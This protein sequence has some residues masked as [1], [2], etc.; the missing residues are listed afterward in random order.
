MSVKLAIAAVA[1]GLLTLGAA[2]ADPIWGLEA[3]GDV[4]PVTFERQQLP[5]GGMQRIRH[6]SRSCRGGLGN[7]IGWTAEGDG[8][9]YLFYDRA[10]QILGRVDA[11]GG[12]AYAGVF[13]DGDTLEMRYIGDS[14]P[15]GHGQV[16]TAPQGSGAG[17]A[18]RCRV[19]AGTRQ[20]AEAYDI[21]EPDASQLMPVVRLNLRF[22][23]NLTS[24][25]VGKVDRGACY[26][27]YRCREEPFADERM[28]CEV[29]L[30]GQTG[31]I[32]KQDETSV[33]ARNICD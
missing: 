7:I 31:W 20:C 11:I 6:Q 15:Q 12:G 1:T 8:S 2:Q 24:Q 21:G 28:W 26:Q 4:C 3:F 9:T 30:E 23:S 29:Q 17:E 33:Y 18:M 13:G 22:S 19:Y 25:I 5:G 10:G 32:L 16:Q 27:V 14:R